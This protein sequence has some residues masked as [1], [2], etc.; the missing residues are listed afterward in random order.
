M[1]MVGGEGW[2]VRRREREREWGAGAERAHA[3]THLNE[4]HFTRMGLD[5][6]HQKQHEDEHDRE[7]LR[8][9]RDVRR[10]R[11]VKVR[12]RI[13]VQVVPNEQHHDEDTNRLAPLLPVRSNAAALRCHR[14][15]E[16]KVEM[17]P[18]PRGR[19]HRGCTLGREL[20]K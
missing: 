18:S 13:Q 1:I 6:E 15:R 5:R 20:F 16:G 8:D 17:I 10:R 7:D 9:E 3:V 4:A 14:A 2:R 12:R 19:V 11:R